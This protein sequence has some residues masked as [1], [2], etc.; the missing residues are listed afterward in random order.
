MALGPEPGK[1]S[2][3]IVCS[4]E[5]LLKI[6][7][8]IG[9]ARRFPCDWPSFLR[10]VL[11]FSCRRLP[12]PRTVGLPRCSWISCAARRPSSAPRTSCRPLGPS[13]KSAA[14]P[15]ERGFRRRGAAFQPLPVRSSRGSSA[16]CGATRRTGLRAAGLR[17]GR[18]RRQLSGPLWRRP[19]GD[20]RK[21]PMT[22][23]WRPATRLQPLAAPC[24]LDQG[25]GPLRCRE[26]EDTLAVSE[27]TGSDGR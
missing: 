6:A 20:R 24:H 23:P 25:V 3:A 12:T 22:W 27:M 26:W 7:A 1:R 19:V 16:R 13:G 9:S 10:C 14:Q 4:G 11:P 17:R 21:T 5:P 15:F 8:T 18:G 2:G